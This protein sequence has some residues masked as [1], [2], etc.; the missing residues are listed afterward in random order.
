MSSHSIVVN[1]DG[2]EQAGFCRVSGL[3]FDF[4]HQLLFER[5]E[6]TFHWRIVPAV[7]LAAHAAGDTRCLQLI[8]K[9][10][11]CILT[12]S[13][14]VKKQI[15]RFLILAMVS[16]LLVSFQAPLRGHIQSA[17]RKYICAYL[18]VLDGADAILFGGGVGENAVPVRERILSGLECCGVVLDKELN[19]AATGREARISAP[20]SKIEAWVVLM[21][22]AV[23]IMQ[24][25]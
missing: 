25:T 14:A 2:V 22:E 18:T 6:K 23:T 3:I 12:S 8:L 10:V 16:D 1:L 19:N 4:V 24:R 5:C 20:G 11:G 13:I 21:D 9:G 17:V 15:G 7:A